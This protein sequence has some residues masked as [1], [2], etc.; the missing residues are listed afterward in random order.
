MKTKRRIILTLA[1][2]IF[3]LAI[4]SQEV[5]RDS[6]LNLLNQVSDKFADKVIEKYKGILK[7]KDIS[8]LE[9]KIYQETEKN[10]DCVKTTYILSYQY[11]KNR[12]YASGSHYVMKRNKNSISK[13]HINLLYEKGMIDDKRKSILEKFTS[14][15]KKDNE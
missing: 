4:F 6:L 15:D 12:S 1:L 7:N 13:E 14:G 8:D 9:M 2:L 5:H 11:Y 3:S 10:K